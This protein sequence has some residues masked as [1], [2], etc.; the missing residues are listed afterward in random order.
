MLT[1]P[2]AAPAQHSQHS[3][4]QRLHFPGLNALRFYAAVSVAY[5]HIYYQITP[6]PIYYHVIN[7][8]IL[9]APSAVNLFF[10]LSGFLITYLLLCEQADTGFVNVGKFYLRRALR[11]W[12]PYYLVTV[13]GLVVF[14]VIFGPAYPLFGLPG[15]KLILAFI[16]L[17]NF[18]SISAPMVHIWTIGVEEQFYAL[19]PW[20]ARQKKRIVPFS[21]GVLII[22]LLLFLV[23]PLFN[24]KGMQDIFSYL[25]FECM[26]IGALGAYAYF[27]KKKIIKWAYP[28][29]VQILA[30][31][32]CSV[33][34]FRSV[35]TTLPNNILFSSAF[36]LIIL[37]VATNPYSL[38]KLNHRLFESLGR[39]S[40]GFYLYHFPSMY[41]VYYG[42]DRLEL[43]EKPFFPLLLLVATLGATGVTA[44][45]SYR[46]LEKPFLDLKTRFTIVR[47][48]DR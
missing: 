41:V 39:I 14:P 10:V 8:F 24:I 35:R 7:F 3:S 44:A 21:F 11:I 15:S 30:W 25:R 47:S 19:W 9:N 23:M 27:E 46:W 43:T 12:P 20:V 2:S 26:A 17:P 31:S 40:Y 32:T 4:L 29:W 37:N 16:L 38:V 18:A 48:C 42:L 36:L 1:Y 5:E 34:I 45:L 28:W 33:V 22:K 13:L 6:K